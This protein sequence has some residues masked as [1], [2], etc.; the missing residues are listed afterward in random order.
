MYISFLELVFITNVTQN[1]CRQHIDFLFLSSLLCVTQYFYHCRYGHFS[2][3]LATQLFSLQTMSR[4]ICLLI[5]LVYTD[6][7]LAL[8]CYYTGLPWVKN[9]SKEIHEKYGARPACLWAVIIDEY[10]N[11]K[12][13]QKCSKIGDIH[14]SACDVLRL[15]EHVRECSLC[16]YDKCNR[17]KGLNSSEKFSFNT[18]LWII[19][20]IISSLL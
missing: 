3:F 16:E 2:L 1:P 5:L 9:C 10:N 6:F 13:I 11:P 19:S 12:E 8:R 15:K 17:L 20:S 18:L 7:S 4:Q 14:L